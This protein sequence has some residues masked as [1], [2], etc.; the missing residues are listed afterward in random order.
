MA[1]DLGRF[2]L[3]FRSENY[4]FIFSGLLLKG[5]GGMVLDKEKIESELE[6]IKFLV[7]NEDMLV[8]EAVAFVKKV[9]KSSDIISGTC[10]EFDKLPEKKKNILINAMED[11]WG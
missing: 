11:E 6:A 10:L 9:K 3:E 1:L 7:E 2:G 5:K 4:S 8:R